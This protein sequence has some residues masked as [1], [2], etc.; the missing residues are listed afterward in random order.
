MQDLEKEGHACGK[1]EM[2]EVE[3]K[4]EKDLEEEGARSQ[5]DDEY[6]DIFQPHMI[7]IST[8]PFVC[9]EVEVKTLDFASLFSDHSLLLSNNCSSDLK[10]LNRVG[11]TALL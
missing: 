1:E 2:A 9:P 11:L 6:L 5:E 3:Y 7:S 4:K 8:S 10:S